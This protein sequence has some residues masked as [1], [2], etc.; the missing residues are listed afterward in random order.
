VT[1]ALGEVTHTYKYD[2]LGRVLEVTNVQDGVTRYE[3][4]G[5]GNLVKKIDPLLNET[6]YEYDV[7]GRLTKITYPDTGGA[8][9]TIQYEYNWRG[10]IQIETDRA[11][12]KTYYNY[13]LAGQVTCVIRNYQA[14][15][16]LCIDPNVTQPQQITLYKYNDLGQLVQETQR[17]RGPVG[18]N[19]DTVTG[20]IYDAAGRIWQ[21]QQALTLHA[22]GDI[23]QYLSTVYTYNA[24]DQVV[25]VTHPDQSITKYTYDEQRR[26]SVINNANETCTYSEYYPSGRLKTQKT[27]AYGSGCN[28]LNT[29]ISETEYQYDPAGQTRKVISDPSGLNSIV[30]YS[31]DALGRIETQTDPRGFVTSYLY[32]YDAINRRRVTVTAPGPSTV[33]GQDEVVTISYYN[34][35]GQLVESVGA[36]GKSTCYE[37]D[38]RGQLLKTLVPDPNTPL[39]C[40]DNP[41]YTESVYDAAG[42]VRFRYDELRNETEYTY[43][44][45][46]RLDTVLNPQNQPTSYD[47]DSVGNLLSIT[48]AAIKTTS[49]AYDR[50]GRQIRKN[51]PDGVR[52][53]EW[54][55]DA[56]NRTETHTV[57]DGNNPGAPVYRDIVSTYD[58]VGRLTEVKYFEGQPGEQ[59][60]TYAYS[61]LPDGPQTVVT[62]C[63]SVPCTGQ[64]T[65]H[66]YDRLG[67]LDFITYPTGHKLDYSYL[68]DGSVSQTQVGTNPPF[69]VTDTYDY[70]YYDNGQVET[71]K[72]DN[73]L[74][75]TF[76]Y[77]PT[78]AT[79]TITYGNQKG[80]EVYTYDPYRD[81]LTSI[82]LNYASG[83]QRQR[84]EYDY[85][86]NGWRDVMRQYDSG[87]LTY[88]I[89]YNYFLSGRLKNEIRKNGS[90][91]VVQRL[92]YFYNVVGN[93]SSLEKITP[94]GTD[95]TTYAYSTDGMNQLQ[96]VTAPGL[97]TNYT[98]DARG[99]VMQINAGSTT[100]NF[101]FDA[102]N[103]V[104]SVSGSGVNVTY[105]YDAD[106]NRIRETD[107]GVTT[108]Y[109]WDPLTAYGDVIYE[110]TT[111]STD[112]HY[113]RANGLLLAQ[114]TGTTNIRYL[115]HDAQGT[116]R[117]MLS[118][119]GASLLESYDYNAFGDFYQPSTMTT[120]FAYTGQQYD[121]ATG[122]YFLR[123]RYYDP[124]IGRFLSQDP[125]PVNTGNPVELNRYVYTANNPV[126]FSDPSGLVASFE[127]ESLLSRVAKAIGGLAAIGTWVANHYLLIAAILAAIGVVAAVSAATSTGTSTA[128]DED[129]QEFN[130]DDVYQEPVGG[131]GGSSGDGNDS[132][133]DPGQ[134]PISFAE[135]VLRIAGGIALTSPYWGSIAAGS[136]SETGQRA[137]TRKGK[138]VRNKKLFYFAEIHDYVPRNTPDIVADM[139][140]ISHIQGIPGMVGQLEKDQRL[141]DQPHERW[142]EYILDGRKFESERAIYFASRGQL[143]NVNSTATGYDLTIQNFHIPTV[144]KVQDKWLLNGYGGGVG[145]VARES[146][147]HPEGTYLAEFSYLT[148]DSK[149]SLVAAGGQEIQWPYP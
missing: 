80:T 67:R 57:P 83:A 31:Y 135:I 42:R 89:D 138:R 127:Y 142:R 107:N 44:V 25:M 46:G 68:I 66:Q 30:Q 117:G 61:Y 129:T 10:D 144:M 82:T 54:D 52:Y 51:W 49:F 16:T 133:D 79:D 106:G 73:A 13:N 100:T 108:T 22:N 97:T 81:F 65:T 15:Q 140:T 78:G 1:N 39:D 14:M 75:A 111:G 123:A 115:T 94:G 149:L 99:N 28:P 29:L 109:V 26:V 147:T 103:K 23:D 69:N 128:V 32:E 4:D 130:P 59:K 118:A 146:Q 137:E 113:T 121:A 8:P 38:A 132:G 125:Y 35:A 18:E 87:S 88:T 5:A 126:N 76:T 11:G 145:D 139:Q 90:G 48:D 114:Q 119:T 21:R 143:A 136:G 110:S 92:N 120:K 6:E 7:L 24:Y 9:A 47:Y 43:D 134:R 148:P 102:R 60:T 122:L 98:Y 84:F 77:T 37:Y 116:S 105:D 36:N 112:R 64:V 41:Y 27:V 17:N 56:V 96:T 34:K 70:T 58:A 104:Q 3:Y 45:L 63:E 85:E 12:I 20:Y 124:A 53:E 91:Q 71:V 50:L 40:T 93:R 62:H 55:Y 141:V 95:T 2:N 86:P 33:Q 101:T 19:N 131:S 72:Y 74:V